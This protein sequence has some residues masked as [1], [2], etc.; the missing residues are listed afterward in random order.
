[1]NRLNLSSYN[2]VDLS[3]IHSNVQG[4]YTRESRADAM[5]SARV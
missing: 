5:D 3:L 4:R 1:V 2:L